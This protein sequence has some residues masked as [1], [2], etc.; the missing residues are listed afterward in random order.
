M[1]ITFLANFQGEIA[2]LTAALIWAIASFVYVHLG[3]QFPPT[4]L[5]LF[6]NSIAILL[7]GITLLL[8]GNGIPTLDP[9]AVGLLAISGAVGIGFGDTVFFEALNCLGS[10][11]ALLMESLAPPLTALLAIAFLQETLANTDYLG[12]GLTITGVA[13]V[14][15]ERAPDAVQR[16]LRPLRGIAF[17]GMAALAQASGAV[18][19]RAALVE[20]DISPLWS[21]LIRLSAGVVLLLLWVGLKP[22]LHQEFPKLRSGKMLLVLTGSAFFSTF[23]AIW[24][25]Q[26]SLKYAEAGVAQSLSAT[27][28]LFVIPIALLLGER[29]SLRALLGAA[30]ALIGI[31]LLFAS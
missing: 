25:Q 31:W 15:V 2:A 7:I 14:V 28:P 11:R 29:V 16:Y 17:G 23:L 12:I 21:S 18:M 8:M 13:W 10:R 5:N 30:I 9:L 24:L 4:L 3:K 20:T 22:Q 6:K 1:E 26:I 19:S 27:S